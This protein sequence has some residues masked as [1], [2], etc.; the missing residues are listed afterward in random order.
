MSPLFVI[1]GVIDTL[2]AALIFFP[3]S[4]AL[5]LYLAVYMIAKGGFF[6]FSGIASKGM[7]PLCMIYCVIDALTGAALGILS[8]GFSL[9]AFSIFG[10]V[11]ILKGLYC[12]VVPVFS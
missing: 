7:N 11:S 4:E 8:F 12:F 9:G 5:I 1:L 3:F 10:Y 6:L 2:A